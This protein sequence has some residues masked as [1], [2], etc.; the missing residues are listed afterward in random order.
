MSAEPREITPVDNGPLDIV[1]RLR[2]TANEWPTDWELVLVLS[3]AAAEI[4]ALRVRIVRLE[5]IVETDASDLDDFRTALQTA[6][7][8]GKEIGDQME[9]ALELLDQRGAPVFE[10]RDL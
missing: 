4:E 1:G 2:L 10:G 7:W 5:E 9:R 8:N 3:D 6:M